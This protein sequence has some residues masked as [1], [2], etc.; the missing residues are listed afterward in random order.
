MLRLIRN[1]IDVQ[2]QIY[3]LKIGDECAKKVCINRKKVN[4]ILQL[5]QDGIKRIL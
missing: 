4:K 5:Y 1:L 3:M 2:K